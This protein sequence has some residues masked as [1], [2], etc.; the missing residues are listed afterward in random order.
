MAELSVNEVNFSY[1]D[2]QI[3]DGLSFE[4]Q[5]GDFVCVLG[6]SGCGKSTLLRLLAGLDF[7]D[8]GSI[9]M[10]G[11]TIEGAGLDRGVVFQDYGLFPWLTVGRNIMMP[12]KKRFPDKTKAEL[13]KL[14]D[15]RLLEV[16]LD[17]H[18]YKKYPGELSG[19]M[20]QRCAICRAL[21][22]DSPIL[23]MDEPFGALDAITR[24]R[25][26]EMVAQLCEE[27]KDQRKTV[28]FVT[29]DVDEAL[30]LATKIVVLGQ[31]P[32]RVIYTYE[33]GER[34][35]RSREALLEDEELQE[36][37]KQLLEALNRNTMER[38]KEDGGC[39]EFERF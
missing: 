37:R 33:F 22:L 1:G 16:G 10:R 2:D 5:E 38:A 30:Y 11:K 4:V 12:L 25:L 36:V 27:K 39:S 20:R 21:L 35:Q 3:L 18:V 23:L 9:E 7:P 15:D 31:K 29:H 17:A 32:S 34:G 24:Y 26:Q 8:S 19:G 14:V 28:V 6:E 13:R